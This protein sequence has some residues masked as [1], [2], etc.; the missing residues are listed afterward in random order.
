MNWMAAIFVLATHAV[1]AVVGLLCIRAITR[2]G[3]ATR[4]ER[5]R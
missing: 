3:A 5:G 4:K 2:D 1:P